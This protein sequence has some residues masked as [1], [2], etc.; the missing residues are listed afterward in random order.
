MWMGLLRREKAMR[1]NCFRQVKSMHSIRCVSTAVLLAS[2][3]MAVAQPAV[4]VADTSLGS[5]PIS[6][7]Y[8]PTSPTNPT[9]T[10]PSNPLSAAITFTYLSSGPN[11]DNLS[12]PIANSSTPA[13]SNEMIRDVVFQVSDHGNLL[14]GAP[15]SSAAYLATSSGEYNKSSGVSGIPAGGTLSYPWSIGLSSAYANSFDLSSEQGFQ[16]INEDMVGPAAN[17]TNYG[18]AGNTVATNYFAPALV[19][20]GGDTVTFDVNIPSL[21]SAAQIQNIYLGYG[22]VY[23]STSVLSGYAP[24]GGYAYI[25]S[26]DPPAVVPEPSTA[27]A[28][29]AM[30]ALAGLF[31]RRRRA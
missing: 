27:A 21:D 25:T 11:G 9:P 19:P 7:Y 12:V 26:S 6:N 22:I 15:T 5:F 1:K 13:S 3:A 2:A 17:G 30:L 8:T 31:I 20:V 16:G 4:A 29:G 24:L 23:G 14:T 18:N 10:D 28:A